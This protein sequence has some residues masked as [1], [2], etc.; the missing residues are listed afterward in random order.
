MQRLLSS[1]LRAQITSPAEIALSV[2]VSK[3]ADPLQESLEVTVDGAPVQAAEVEGAEGSRWHLLSDVPA[4]QL[5]VDYRATVDSGGAASQLSPMDRIHWIRPSRYVDVDRL[6]NVSRQLFSELTGQEL[7]LAV[8]RYVNDTTAYIPGSSRVTDGASETFMAKAGV[9]RDFAHLTIALLRA[10]G[11]P[12]RLVSAY[13][14]GL[15]P[16]DF[17][18]VV[19]AH[20]EGQWHVV[21]PTRLA[22]RSSLVR[23]ATGADAAETA[24]MTIHTGTMNFQSVNVSAIAVPYLESD[25]HSGLIQLA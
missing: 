12:A 16:M 5:V 17:H 2:M 8:A 15:S 19:E 22:P 4:G 10:R 20:V 23:I 24:F 6:E 7:L 14:P 11:V 18:A 25:D 3:Q 21:D 13:A 9:C 1:S